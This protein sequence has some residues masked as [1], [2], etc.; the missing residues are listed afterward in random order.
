MKTSTNTVGGV[1]CQSTHRWFPHTTIVG[2]RLYRYGHWVWISPWGWTWVDDAPGA[3]RH[4]ITA[5]G[6]P[7]AEFGAGCLVR[8]AQLLCGLRTPVYARRS[9]P[10][11]E[12]PHFSVGIGIGGGGGVGV[13]WFPTCPRE[14]LRAFLPLQAA[15]TLQTSMSPNT[16]VN[17]TVVNNYTHCRRQQAGHQHQ[18]REPDRAQRGNR[19]IARNFYFRASCRARHDEN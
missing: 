15:P 1:R 13:A 11:L 3:L 10:G 12:G 18:I 5:A 16:T 2:W 7:S 17:T 8:H 19:H 14:S 6:L 4:S 9:S